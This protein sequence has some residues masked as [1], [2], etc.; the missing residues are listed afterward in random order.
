MSVQLSMSVDEAPAVINSL[1]SAEYE[2]ILTGSSSNVNHLPLHDKSKKIHLDL[3][4]LKDLRFLPAGC[5]SGAESLE[6]VVFDCL[7]ANLS[8]QV[9]GN[10]SF[11]Y[12]H[13]LE[14]IVLPNSLKV[15][16][17]EAFCFCSSL[18]EIRFEG[19]KEEW[20]NIVKGKDWSYGVSA[21]CVQ[22]KDG[23]VEVEQLYF[24]KDNYLDGVHPKI[25]SI[26]LPASCAGIA[27]GKAIGNGWTTEMSLENSS[28]EKITV[29]ADN[30]NLVAFDN[31]LYGKKDKKLIACPPKKSGVLT[32]PK[33]YTIVFSERKGYNPDYKTIGVESN[34]VF[35]KCDGITEIHFE[36]S[37]KKIGF[38]SGFDK[39]YIKRNGNDFKLPV[40]FT[41]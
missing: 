38:L 31:V 24:N 29:A 1:P 17:D 27:S 37:R 21:L 34:G 14:R 5:F 11:A 26:A 16:G 30:E 9:I 3:C 6:S 33:G 36:D 2:I 13:N 23:D 10:S 39:L 41:V 4:N 25:T 19:T 20:N 28:V 35:D 8:L 12:C 7:E 15:I 18:S 32:V 22:C 40:R